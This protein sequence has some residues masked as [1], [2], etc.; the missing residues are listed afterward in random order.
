MDARRAE[1]ELE[2]RRADALLTACDLGL[3]DDVARLISG[4]ATFE[5]TDKNGF[6]PMVFASARGHVD[7]VELLLSHGVDPND[8]DKDGRTPLHFAAMHDNLNVVTL[9]ANRKGTWVDQTDCNDD[10]PLL[11]AVRM[12]GVDTV[13]ALL[14][15]GASINS[16]N[17]LGNTPITEAAII[18]RRFDVAD[19]ILEHASKVDGD[20][21]VEHLVKTKVGRS[22]WSLVHAAKALGHDDAIEWL[23]HKG[24]DVDV[25][26]SE[27][28]EDDAMSSLHGTTATGTTI[29]TS[30]ALLKPA[31]QLKLVRAWA[32]IAPEK[33]HVKTNAIPLPALT[34]LEKRDQ[35]LAD[36]EKYDF[37]QKLVDDDEFQGD[38]NL[39]EVRDAVDAVVKDFNNVV[40]YKNDQRILRTLNKF[41][42]VQ[43]FCKERGFR[44]NYADV[45][46]KGL[47]EVDERRQRVGGLREAAERALL[48]AVKAVVDSENKI[49]NESENE[50][51]SHARFDEKFDAPGV[52]HSFGKSLR[53]NVTQLAWQTL[54]H[55]LVAAFCFWLTVYVFGFK[56]PMERESSATKE[57]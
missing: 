41:R 7:V 16:K 5:A 18:R 22:K 28:N 11:L 33:R 21:G 1:A 51:E 53:L 54:Y 15:C 42:H 10:T 48:D 26:A 32:S 23:R 4:G 24:V 45:M 56:N 35:L 30:F 46:V 47:D 12:A 2:R 39:T 40:R 44:I 3:A 27:R 8:D 13:K 31:A 50:M 49:E 6:R 55:L 17:K 57:L 9:L 19:V 38:M 25:E 36:I 20:R 34:H 29:D 52:A 43:K 37:L 14:E